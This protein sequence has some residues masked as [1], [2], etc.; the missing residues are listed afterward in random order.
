MTP[1]ADRPVLTY[2]NSPSD[3]TTCTALLCKSRYLSFTMSKTDCIAPSFSRRNGNGFRS[4]SGPGIS[5][6][7][8]PSIVHSIDPLP[9][10]A[11]RGSKGMVGLG[12]LELP[13]SR[14]SGVY[15]NQLSYWPQRSESGKIM[16]SLY[17]VKETGHIN[18]VRIGHWL[19]KHILLA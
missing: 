19:L 13:T 15:S 18:G 8:T 11:C 5:R 14:L 7:L 12:R 2:L 4:R 3:T 17:T 16:V 9:V 6:L 1:A 10:P